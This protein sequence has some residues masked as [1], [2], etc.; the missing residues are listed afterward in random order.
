[1]H[2]IKCTESAKRRPSPLGKTVFG[3]PP[4]PPWPQDSS[5]LPSPNPPQNPKS[6]QKRNKNSYCLLRLPIH[7]FVPPNE[8]FP[9]F[10]SPLS[11]SLYLSDFLTGLPFSQSFC[12]KLFCLITSH[13]N[14]PRISSE[15]TTFRLEN[16]KLI[17]NI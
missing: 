10:Y 5:H 12:S 4:S 15:Q 9:C 2:T 13:S 14:C 6:I 8:Q 1:M 3:P 7:C 16:D 11:D 17:Y